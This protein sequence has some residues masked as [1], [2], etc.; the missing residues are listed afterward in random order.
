[1]PVRSPIQ[2]GNA[3]RR[4]RKLKGM[5]QTDL[6]QKAGLTQATISRIEK[7]NQKAEVSTLILIFAALDAD[8]AI[9]ERQKLDSSD[10]LEGLF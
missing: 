6:A 7:G 9:T 5:S 4:L 8:M 1:M 2:V 3:I 10:S